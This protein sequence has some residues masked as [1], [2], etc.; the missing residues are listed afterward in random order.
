MVSDVFLLPDSE[1]LVSYVMGL[2]NIKPEEAMS[3]FTG[4][5]SQLGPHGS[6]VPVPNAN[7]LIIT[8]NS[9]LIRTLIEIKNRIDIP[10]NVMI[11]SQ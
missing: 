4:V 5:V 3:I 9:Q 2:E 11:F 10:L 8:E 1:E 7:A 6:I